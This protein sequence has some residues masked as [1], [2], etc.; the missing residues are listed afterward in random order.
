M[1][2]DDMSGESAIDNA[3]KNNSIFCIKA[4]I[5]NLLEI[6]NDNQFRNC[7]DKGLLL[8]VKKGMKVSDLCKS[9]LFYPTIWSN[10][11][12]FSEI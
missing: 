5:D 9:S 1:Y 2:Q 6:S 11:K 3:F 10:Y 4:F 7:F 8:M 12:L